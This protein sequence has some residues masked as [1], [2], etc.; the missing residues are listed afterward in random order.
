MCIMFFKS[1]LQ[2]WHPFHMFFLQVCESLAH[3]RRRCGLAACGKESAF[4][5]LLSLICGETSYS[6][7]FNMWWNILIGYTNLLDII[8]LYHNLLYTKNIHQSQKNLIDCIMM[9]VR[10]CNETNTAC[11]YSNCKWGLLLIEIQ[12]FRDNQGGLGIGAVPL[13]LPVFQMYAYL[14]N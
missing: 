1:G 7:N 3:E 2:T 14:Q 6:M 8:Y 12:R 10:V 9:W 11:P 5:N 4:K 13:L